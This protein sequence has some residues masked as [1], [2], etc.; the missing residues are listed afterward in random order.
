MTRTRSD[1]TRLVR[2]T[3]DRLGPVYDRR[4]ARYIHTTTQATGETV[5]ALGP[6]VLEAGKGAEGNAGFGLQNLGGLARKRGAAHLVAL[7]EI[8][9]GDGPGGGRVAAAGAADDLGEVGL[10]GGVEDGAGR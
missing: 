9:G 8:G 5:G 2:E 4:W 10:G 3:F 7:L 1:P 6:G